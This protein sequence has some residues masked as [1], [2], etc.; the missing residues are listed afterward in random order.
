MSDSTAMGVETYLYDFE[1]DLYGTDIIVQFLAFRRPE[2]KFDS[3]ESLKA[4]LVQD[5]AAG[6]K[7]DLIH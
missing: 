6:E 1:G 7:V 5:I 3:V 4:Q 2:K